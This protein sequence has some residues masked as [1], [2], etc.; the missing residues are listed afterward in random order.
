MMAKSEIKLNMVRSDAYIRVL[1]KNS[2][3]REEMKELFKEHNDA[4]EKSLNAIFRK[5]DALDGKK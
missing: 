1:D 4:V 2:I 5:L 3:T